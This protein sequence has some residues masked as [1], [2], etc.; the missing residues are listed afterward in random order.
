MCIQSYCI[1]FRISAAAELQLG[2]TAEHVLETGSNLPDNGAG[3]LQPKLGNLI[4]RNW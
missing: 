2:S 1:N 4:S 3:E